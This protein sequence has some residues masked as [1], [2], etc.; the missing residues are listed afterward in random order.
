MTMNTKIGTPARILMQREQ[1]GP[2]EFMNVT[3]PDPAPNQVLVQMLATGLCQSQIYWM[4]QPRKAPVL[5]GHEGY[6]IAM[7]VGTEVT[8]V[9]EGDPVLVTWI[10][11][12]EASGRAPEVA[13][14]QLPD[15]SMA[16]APNCYT[17]ADHALLDSLYV[18]PIRHRQH[19]PLY[20][21]IGCA[22]M[23]GAGAVMH[24][25]GL[26]EGQTV[27]VYGVGGVGLSA[28][29]AARVAG[30]SR[31][32]AG[33]L[34]DAMLELARHF[35]ATHGINSRHEDPV[36]RIHDLLPGHCGCSGTD[37]ALDVV[38]LPSTT[39]QALASVRSGRLGLQRGGHC[40]VVGVPKEP[41]PIDTLDM[42]FKEKTLSGSLG[43]SS[44]Q[45]HID[46]YI[47]W[48]QDGRLD[49]EALVTHRYAFE[50]IVEGAQALELGLIAGRAVAFI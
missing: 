2:L 48:C 12:N 11:R 46:N 10:P 34:D 45:A 3:L 47:D 25:G 17:W 37:L 36:T 20:A 44:L 26:R 33:D 8:D 27:A 32:I 21:V 7:K 15:G 23:T 18:K 6:G 19:D 49:L 28:V 31:I 30:A 35:G 39:R 1:H 4:H 16:R 14:V 22:V 50:E 42:M 9:R 24:T 5:F 13:T 29:A 40:V 38:G 43:G 41:V